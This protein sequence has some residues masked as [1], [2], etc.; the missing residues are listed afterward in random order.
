[1][2]NRELIQLARLIPRADKLEGFVVGVGREWLLLH[3][4]NPDLFL[5]GHAALRIDDARGVKGLG[6]ASF[7]SRALRHFHERPR[8]LPAIELGS[9]SSLIR[10]TAKNF[11]LATI[12][13]E[14]RDPNVCFIGV[15]IARTRRLLKLLEITPQ[16]RWN[17]KASIYQL[18]DITRVEVG[19]RYEKAL[20]AVG[21][22][23]PQLFE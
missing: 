20:L 2:A 10:S 11:S 7:A 15:P 1:M 9:T 23:A 12:H 21:G 5:D 18:A 17:E 4:L 13:L 6:S 22:P 8:P 14:R 19:G 16:A 3:L